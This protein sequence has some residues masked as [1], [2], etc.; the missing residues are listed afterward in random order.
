MQLDESNLVILTKSPLASQVL[1]HGNMRSFGECKYPQHLF[2]T[3]YQW[4]DS[5]YLNALTKYGV[6]CGL[7]WQTMN[8]VQL[9]SEV[10]NIDLRQNKSRLENL[11]KSTQVFAQITDGFTDDFLG[12]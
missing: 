11:L 7:L 6:R 2:C 10:L 8:A 9:K 1:E 4:S 3:K 12:N 5:G